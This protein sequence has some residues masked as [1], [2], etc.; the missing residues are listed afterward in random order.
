ML[1]AACNALRTLA[2][3]SAAPDTADDAFLLAGR[4][5]AYCP[6]HLLVPSLLAAVLDSAAA[7]LLVQHRYAPAQ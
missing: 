3:V 6:R 1:G 7:G 4:L 2:E 5:L